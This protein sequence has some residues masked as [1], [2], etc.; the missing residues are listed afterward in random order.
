MT[1]F[2]VAASLAASALPLCAQSAPAPDPT[3]LTGANYTLYESIKRNLT[4]AA[5]QM[6]EEHYSFRPSADV[7]SFGQIIGHIANAQYNFC[8]AALGEAR[9]TQENYE[10]RTTRAGLVEALTSSFT[11]CDRAQRFVTDANAG[12]IVKMFGADRPRMFALVYNIAHDN[13]HYGN[14]VTY[15]RMKGLVP[16]SSQR[17]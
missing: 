13:E 10:Q 11:Y 5:E 16:P 17:G 6:P 2:L 4:R 9:P 12:E 1:R 3:S 15:M 7:R 8:A 14:L